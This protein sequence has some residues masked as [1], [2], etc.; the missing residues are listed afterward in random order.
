MAFS[1]ADKAH[2]ETDKVVIYSTLENVRYH[3]LHGNAALDA[4][5]KIA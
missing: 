3:V 5:G 1:K 2:C 4:W